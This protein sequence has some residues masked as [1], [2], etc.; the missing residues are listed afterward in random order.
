VR[1]K[2]KK[3]KEKRKAKYGWS[4]EGDGGNPPIYAHIQQGLETFRGQQVDL[5]TSAL[6]ERKEEMKKK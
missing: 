2:E 6:A 1:K 5:N 3:R 4:E